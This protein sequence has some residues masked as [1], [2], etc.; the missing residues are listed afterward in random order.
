MAAEAAGGG[1]GT[2]GAAERAAPALSG[3]RTW[4]K[5]VM[6]SGWELGAAGALGWGTGGWVDGGG[7]PGRGVV[8]LGK[9]TCFEALRTW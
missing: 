7:M 3:R 8:L 1:A 4:Q 6:P 9:T 5:P 2:A